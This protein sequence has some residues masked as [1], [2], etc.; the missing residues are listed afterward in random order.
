M[1]VDGTYDDAVEYVKKQTASNNWTLVADQSWDGYTDIP[2]NIMIGYTT[3]FQEA[4]HQAS[5]YS[6]KITHVFIQAGVGGLAAACAAWCEKERI[7]ND[8]RYL[9]RLICV[10]PIDA[11][12]LME[13]AKNNIISSSKG[14]TNSIMAGLNCGTPSK[15]AWNLLNDTVDC[16]I[17]I[18]DDWV[19]ETMRLMKYS[20]GHDR[21][22][23]SGE[24]GSAGIAGLLSVMTK[25]DNTSNEIKI[26]L[27]LNADSVILCVNT[28]GDTDANLYKEIVKKK[29]T[30]FN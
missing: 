3:I 16:F 25:N 5:F 11:D 29:H 12:C 18:G 24:S 13:S 7:K 6:G 27:G 2:K 20:F 10:E 23:I 21:S 30:I 28:E 9:P 1:I 4:F 22:I 17:T 8:N 14:G 19:M 26:L 15:I